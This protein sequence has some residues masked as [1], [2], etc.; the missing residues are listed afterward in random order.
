MQTLEQQLIK[1]GSYHRDRRNLTTHV[2]GIPLIVFA[3]VVLMSRPAWSMLDFLP[4]SPALV[5]SV[6]AGIYYLR[7]D[8]RIGAVMSVFLFLSLLLAAPL[9]ALPTAT[10]F[11]IG[12]GIFVAGWVLQFIGHIYEGRKPAFVDDLMGLIIGPIF[13]IAMRSELS[14]AIDAVIGPLRRGGTATANQ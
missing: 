9:A 7:L 1:Y 2:I 14:L 3:V 11:S 8:L 6:I 12:I 5:A 10:F 13:V 4:L